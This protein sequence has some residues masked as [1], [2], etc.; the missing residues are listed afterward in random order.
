MRQMVIEAPRRAAVQVAELP[1]PGPGEVR[2]RLE[3]CGVCGSNL[4]VWNGQPWFTYPFP[5]GAPGHE[6]WGVIDRIGSDVSGLEPG[7][8][9]AMLSSHAYAD[10][11]V[12]AADAVVPIPERLGDRC[13]PG[14]A[15]AC[16]L[17]VVRRA[18]LQPGT[19]VAVVGIGFLG[20]AIV[21]LASRQSVRV[22][23]VSRRRFALDVAAAQGAVDLVTLDDVSAAI[24]R[25]RAAAGPDGYDTVIEAAGTQAALD[26]ASAL[27]GV[28]GR[29]VIAGYHQDGPRQVDM[30]SWNWRG[31]DVINAHER[32]SGAYV[33][34]MRAALALANRGE[35]DPWT[36]ITHTLPLAE[37]DRALTLLS[38][39]PDGFLKAVVVP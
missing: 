12:A 28:R 24:G 13:L 16:A 20:A 27:V 3:G 38:T 34:G 19:R 2:V 18:A 1:E 8:R 33:E 37:L 5:P 11:D 7:T 22:T 31:L 30:Q 35:W 9:V 26:V 21:R 36:L 14:E 25:A 32:D 6:G 15:L 17:N 29:L 23:A 4:P 10:F 39:R